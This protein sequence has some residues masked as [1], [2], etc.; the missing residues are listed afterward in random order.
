MSDGVRIPNAALRF[1]PKDPLSGSSEPVSER[2]GNW[3]QVWVPGE[4]NGVRPVP[5]LT[6]ASDERFTVLLEGDLREGD[7]VVIGYEKVD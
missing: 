5:I 6:G 3:L 4:P 7:P 1:V 2:D